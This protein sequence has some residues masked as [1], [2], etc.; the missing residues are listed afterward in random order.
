MGNHRKQH[1]LHWALCAL[2][3]AGVI[4]VPLTTATPALAAHTRAVPDRVLRKGDHGP[5]VRRLQHLLKLPVDGIFGPHTKR[6]VRRFQH[7]HHLLADGQVGSHTWRALLDSRPPRRHTGE[8]GHDGILRLGDRGAAVAGV[9]RLLHIHATGLYDRRTLRAVRRFQRR[10]H[11]VADGQ[12]GPHTLRALHRASRAGD[13]R[14]SP[15]RHATL[16][17]RAVRMAKHYIGVRYVWGGESPHGFDCSGLVQF[18]YR[19]LGV[20]LPRVTYAQWHAGRHISRTQL[21][22]G[23]LVFFHHHGHVGIYVGHGWFLHAP[24]TGE[25]VHA[26]ELSHSWFRRHYDGAVRVR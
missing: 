4:A 3:C 6:A 20:E 22:P 13:E 19:K 24:R 7:Q 11:L 17:S 21:R 14:R 1:P 23:D 2:A 16:G 12:V 10:H 18:V 25:R 5:L 9:Q 15:S 8:H 26:S